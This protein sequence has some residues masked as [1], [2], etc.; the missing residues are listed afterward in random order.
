MDARSLARGRWL[1]L[2]VAIVV[3]AACGSQASNAGAMVFLVQPLICEEPEEEESCY[4]A[5][6]FLK[7]ETGSE[8]LEFLE[9]PGPSNGAAISPDEEY[10]AWTEAG[11]G[12]YLSDMELRSSVPLVSYEAGGSGMFW[13]YDDPV[14]APDQDLVLF[15]FE[16]D[17]ITEF[18]PFPLTNGEELHAAAT[19]EGED[20]EPYG[21]WAGPRRDPALSSDGGRAA[22]VA[23]VSGVQGIWMADATGGGVTP[24]VT[25]ADGFD[26]LASPSFAP[27]GNRLA[28]EGAPTRGE[29]QIYVVGTNGGELNQ[30][31]R[32]GGTRPQW[33]P[34]ESFIA[35]TGSS[36]RTVERIDPDTGEALSPLVTSTPEPTDGVYRVVLPQSDALRAV[37]TFEPVLRFDSSENW[38]PVNVDEFLAEGGHVLCEEEECDEEPIG[39]ASDL[40]SYGTTDSYIDIDGEYGEG[41]SSYHTPTSGCIT[42]GLLDC[43]AASSSAIYYRVTRPFFEEETAY[44]YIDYWFFYRAN[45]FVSQLGFHEGDWEGVTVAPSATTPGTFDYAAFSQHGT[46]YSYLR[47]VLRCED[48]ESESEPPEAGTCG[49]EAEPE[50]QRISVMVANGTHANYTTPCSETLPGD[51]SQNGEGRFDRGYDGERRWGNA[52]ASP[53]VTLL[54]LPPASPGYEPGEGPDPEAWASGP[55]GWADWP[56]GWGVPGGGLQGDGPPSPLLQGVDIACATIDNPEGFCDG[57]PRAASASGSVDQPLSPGLVAMSCRSWIGANVSAALCNPRRLRAAVRRGRMGGSP[58]RRLQGSGRR[59]GAAAAPGVV[60]LTGRPLRHGSRV[61][62]RG[63]VTRETTLMLRV[64]GRGKNRKTVFVARFSNVARHLR[65][66][67]ARTSSHTLRLRT[68]RGRLRR[69]TVRLGGLRPTTVRRTG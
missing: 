66:R 42:E 43:D 5:G 67:N 45:E 21:E 31:T 64:R 32:S 59:R 19:G 25:R 44:R 2:V 35:Y 4:H 3:A 47:D 38:R 60:Q 22:F 46:Y 7:G 62:L 69:S 9:L 29:P 68:G 48:R 53:Y 61:R 65:S 23:T 41:T 11:G 12:L 56:G 8:R 10:I 20:P 14:F 40:G 63:K 37:R 26:G 13:D 54:P 33:S 6:G 34:D 28:F 30:L 50:G 36:M 51:C 1:T 15:N 27:E 16:A 49:T 18:C 17:C 58:S 52:F 57:G 39:G 24:V 55:R